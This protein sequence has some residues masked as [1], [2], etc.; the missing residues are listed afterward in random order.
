LKLR[1]SR[2]L[3]DFLESWSHTIPRLSA[4]GPHVHLGLKLAWVIQACRPEPLEVWN[5]FR[6]DEDG[7]ATFWT[8]PSAHLIT[9]L[10]LN[11]VRRT[12]SRDSERRFGNVHH[13]TKRAPARV[14]TILTVTIPGK[15]RSRRALIANGAARTTTSKGN[16]HRILFWRMPE[17]GASP[18]C[19]RTQPSLQ[20]S[21]CRVCT[22]STHEPETGELDW[23]ERYRF[24]R[25]PA[26]TVI[27]LISEACSKARF[28]IRV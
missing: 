24:L 27:D 1:F 8:K 21:A 3:F 12:L 16:Q 23:Q 15:N 18:I 10:C 13:W 14:L 19:W 9:A 25:N 5:K 2:G 17:I 4:A 28:R 22:D 7:R 26:L 20:S 11:T 6:Q